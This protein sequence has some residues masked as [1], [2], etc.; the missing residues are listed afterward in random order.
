M[1]ISPD[2]LKW[3]TKSPP[4]V[5]VRTRWG[6]NSVDALPATIRTV[7]V[8]CAISVLDWPMRPWGRPMSKV[9]SR[10]AFHWGETHK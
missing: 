3:G 5:S 10:M 8:S 1:K 7:T 4:G 2:A 6:T 9:T